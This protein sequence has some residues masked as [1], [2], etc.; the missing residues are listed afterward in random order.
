MEQRNILHYG[1][2]RSG[3]NFLE[4]LLNKN[5]KVKI[6][7]DSERHHPL[8]KHFRL[9][10]NKKHIPEP[11]FI[12]DMHFD[13]FDAFH[14]AL[15]IGDQMDGIIVVS[16]DPYSWFLSYS[17]WARKCEWELPNYH[18]IEEYNGFYGKWNEFRKENPKIHFVRYIDL[19]IN[20]KMEMEIIQEKFELELKSI[21]K[22]RGLKTQFGKISM[23]RS[24]SS[25]RLKFYT[26]KQYLKKLDK[27]SFE[28]INERLD[29]SLMQD[30]GYDVEG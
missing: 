12:N 2:Q 1:L 17:N 24:F 9:Y 11:K 25:D 3:T 4:T 8:H 6:V 30:L 19:L 21:R 20:P 15:G 28:A 18:Y 14:T 27:Q 10:D 13:S 22:M 29:K 5:F 16:K 23:S 7:F 26:E